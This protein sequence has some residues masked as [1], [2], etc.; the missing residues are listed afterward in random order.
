MA[1]KRKLKKGVVVFLILFCCSLLAS[2]C[3]LIA[4]NTQAGKEKSVA[5]NEL[6]DDMIINNLN[7]GEKSDLSENGQKNVEIEV[8][9]L[10]QTLN[11]IIAQDNKLSDYMIKNNFPSLDSEFEQFIRALDNYDSTL[12]F[13]SYEFEKAGNVHSII[14]D[15]IEITEINK[16]KGLYKI[17]KP[18][19]DMF[20]FLPDGEGN[21]AVSVNYD[22]IAEKYSDLLSEPWQIY[23]KIR[24]KQY[25]HGR[26][27]QDGQLVIP[28][29]NIAEQ[30]ADLINFSRQYPTFAM[31]TKINEDITDFTDKLTNYPMYTSYRDKIE[32]TKESKRAVKKV[33]EKI[34]IDSPEYEILKKSL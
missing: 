18:K 15:G 20:T 11:N 7:T 5:A 33:I 17:T 27:F 31:K 32:T 23:I 10:K 30:L 8:S 25:K 4:G 13:D 34:P 1:K 24:Q 16:S 29:N 26:M 14:Q 2:I 19:A 3:I 6:T 9:D 22:Y 21:Y 28:A 12:H